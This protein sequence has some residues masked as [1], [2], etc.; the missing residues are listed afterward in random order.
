M[1]HKRQSSGRRSKPETAAIL[2]QWSRNLVCASWGTIWHK[3][4]YQGENKVLSRHIVIAATRGGDW[5]QRPD[6]ESATPWW[7]SVYKTQNG[8]IRRMSALNVGEKKLE[9]SILKQLFMQR[10]PV[11]VQL[12]LAST[13]ESMG[14]NE[15]AALA[16]RIL[17]VASPSVACVDTQ[18]C[19][20]P[21]TQPQAYFCINNIFSYNIKD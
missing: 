2:G 18:P 3:R 21:H 7:R 20:Q 13:S 8:T 1:R 19:T 5:G 6:S 11:N 4:D 10:L 14:I 9:P 15:L 12:I 17:E 16:D